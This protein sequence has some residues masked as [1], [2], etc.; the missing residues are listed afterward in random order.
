[1]IFRI[2]SSTDDS[3]NVFNLSSHNLS[4]KT[5]MILAKLFAHDQKFHTLK[6]ND[7][8]LSSDGIVDFCVLFQLALN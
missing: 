4:D 8:S 3:V 1:M 2:T 6:L 7:A 5:C